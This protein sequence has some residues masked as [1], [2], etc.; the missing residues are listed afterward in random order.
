MRNTEAIVKKKIWP[1]MS[2]G[3]SSFIALQKKAGL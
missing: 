1:H 2:A 3:L